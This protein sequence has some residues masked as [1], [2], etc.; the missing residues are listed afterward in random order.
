MKNLIT[1]K[2]LN[3]FKENYNSSNKNF[4]AENAVI[5]N[6]ILK[7]AKTMKST[8]ENTHEYSVEINTGEIT[9]QKMSGRCWMFAAL[10]I[11]RL[12]IMDKLNL[13]TFELSQSYP[14][15]F[16]KLEKSNHFLENIIETISLPLDSREVA[17]RKS[18]V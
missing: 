3:K 6:G 12:E 17:D 18:V 13:E 1:N 16:D 10:N 7:S 8:V 11:M 4:V 9:N 5:N 2:Q 14:F 15:F